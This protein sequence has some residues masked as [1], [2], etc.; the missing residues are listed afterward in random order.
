M[1]RKLYGWIRKPGQYCLGR[2]PPDSPQMPYEVYASLDEVEQA[3]KSR[4]AA[5][6]WCGD[7]ATEKRVNG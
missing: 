2:N 6:I 4:K 7:A 3:A 1:K 5:V